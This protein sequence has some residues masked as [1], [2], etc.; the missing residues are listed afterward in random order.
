L[1]GED[2]GLEGV[3]HGDWRLVIFGGIGHGTGY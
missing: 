2:E 1:E 3:R